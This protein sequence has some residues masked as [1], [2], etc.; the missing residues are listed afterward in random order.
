M[1]NKKSYN[2]FS[3]LT[4]D[5]ENT[6]VKYR[7]YLLASLPEMLGQ[8]NI[9]TQFIPVQLRDIQE[10][11]PTSVDIS[12]EAALDENQRILIIGEAGSGKTTLLKYLTYGSAKGLF[13]NISNVPV[14]INASN[15]L[16]PFD[17]SENIYGLIKRISGKELKYSDLEKLLKMGR[18]LILLDGINESLQ[19]DGLIQSFNDFVHR[20]PN[21][22][23]VLTSR[24]LQEYLINLTDFRTYR[25]AEMNDASIR[26]NIDN[27]SSNYPTVAE[28]C[29]NTVQENPVLKSLARNPVHLR[30]IVES[31]KESPKL[32]HVSITETYLKGFLPALLRKLPNSAKKLA[33]ILALYMYRHELMIIS[34]DEIQNL[35]NHFTQFSLQSDLDALHKYGLL[36]VSQVHTYHFVHQVVQEYFCVQELISMDFLE[37]KEIINEH[38]GNERWEQ[39]FTGL[40]VQRPERENLISEFITGDDKNRWLLGAK[41]LLEGEKTDQTTYRR[42]IQN[43]CSLLNQDTPDTTIRATNYLFKFRD[44]DISE[45]CSQW[46]HRKSGDPLSTASLVFILIS[47]GK[48]DA[49]ILSLLLPQVNNENSAVRYQTCR[50]LSIIDTKQSTELLID[51]LK[52]EDNTEVREQIFSALIKTKC[53]SQIRSTELAQL[54]AILIKL[55][56]NSE[57]LDEK[58]WSK[59][60]FHKIN[61]EIAASEVK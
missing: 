26:I 51:C 11:L 23:Y 15:L 8:I 45:I 27:W 41:I 53:M 35:E 46:L 50:T 37:V 2:L 13:P 48:R 14:I 22:H 25:I 32:S 39:V 43:L 44:P 16:Y 24:P 34:Y 18:F 3:S 19:T 58:A 60:V 1:I 30:L 61:T 21:N 4:Q 5:R 47:K 42:A 9:E 49:E 52:Q 29:W 20:Y 33:Q 6:L 31:C 55:N 59:F 40:L 7:E 28:T 57:S 38:I 17:L 36:V 10:N 12:I 56:K 54:M